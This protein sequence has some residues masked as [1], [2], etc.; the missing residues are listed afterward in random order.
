MRMLITI[1]RKYLPCFVAGIA[2]AIVCFVGLNAVMK[3]FSLSEYCG[4]NC[5]EMRTA[6]QSWELS[7][8]G[9]NGN[10][11]ITHCVDCHLPSK[12]HY[13]AHMATK[14]YVGAIDTLKHHFGPEYDSEQMRQKVLSHIPNQRCLNCHDN[15]LAKP[16]SSAARLAHN[17]VLSDPGKSEHRCVKCHEDAGHQRVRKIFTP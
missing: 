13:F 5:H 17:S 1:A 9:S 3:P 10:G 7:S 8:H 15:L 2:F 16:A 4:S 14:A 12:D 6:Y 11:V